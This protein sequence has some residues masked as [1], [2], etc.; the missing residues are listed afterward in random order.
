[1]FIYFLNSKI[2][3]NRVINAVA[4]TTFGIYLIHDDIW[5]KDMLW[6]KIIC[7]SVY[8][9]NKWLVLY[10]ICVILVVFVICMLIDF[11]RKMMLAKPEQMISERITAY[12]SKVIYIIRMKLVNL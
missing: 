7:Q 10:S 2:S 9:E 1:M 3:Y 4:S 11:C 12:V 6:H 5:I 8:A